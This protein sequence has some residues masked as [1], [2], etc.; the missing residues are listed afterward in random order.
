VNSSGTVY[1]NAG[2][3]SVTINAS[4]GGAPEWNLDPSAK[5]WRLR[6]EPLYPLAAAID[7]GLM[8][9]ADEAA[10]GDDPGAGPVIC[11]YF[12]EDEIEVSLWFDGYSDDH[13]A[14]RLPVVGE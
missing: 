12:S 1:M 11:V 3:V 13:I 14:V 10:A 2:T 5:V 4:G 9:L 7:S 8:K 6:L